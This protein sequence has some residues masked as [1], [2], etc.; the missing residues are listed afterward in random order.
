MGTSFSFETFNALIRQANCARE[1]SYLNAPLY[2]A[3]TGR[4]GLTIHEGYGAVL[5]VCHHPHIENRLLVFPEVGNAGGKLTV[6]VLESLEAPANGVQLAR[7]STEDLASLSAAFA[8]RN[9]SRV[10]CVK[11]VPEESLDWRYP[12]HILGTAR[13]AALKGSDFAKIRNKVRKVESGIEVLSLQ[14]PRALRAMR[15][16]QKYWEGSMVMRE[17]DGDDLEG[18]YSALFNRIGAQPQYFNGLVFMQ[19]SRPVGFTVYDT[20]FMGTA[21]ML[22][23]LSDASIA[24]LADFQVVAT[25]R[26]MSA[27]GIALM[28][29]GGS[30]TESLDQ[31][32]R[33]FMPCKSLDLHSAEVG[34]ALREDVNVRSGVLVP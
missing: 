5:A 21:N 25:C 4:K 33:K 7:Y 26:A 20:P 3:L 15:A 34:Y 2:Y 12:V 13:V 9:G 19:G 11:I 14:D 6:S 31:Y 32:K 29:F 24:G 22:A 8:E 1:D 18:F 27:A 30:E 16:A 17:K 10:D 28:N 23:N